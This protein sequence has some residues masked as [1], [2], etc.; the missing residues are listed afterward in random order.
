MILLQ[1]AMKNLS[2]TNTLANLETTFNKKK[3]LN[4]LERKNIFPS[5]PI[6][7]KVL[8]IP[9]LVEIE[10]D[11]IYL[12]ND[13]IFYERWN[14]EIKN[15]QLLEYLLPSEDL[16]DLNKIQEMTNTI[17]EYDFLNLIFKI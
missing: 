13:N 7:N 6:R 3:I 1:L 5:M 17:E 11:N 4:Y 12:F 9:I 15:Y 16:E 8:L 2:I 14:D 10:T